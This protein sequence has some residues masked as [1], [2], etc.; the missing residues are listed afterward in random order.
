MCIETCTSV[1]GIEILL[2]DMLCISLFWIIKEVAVVDITRL[3]EWEGKNLRVLLGALD[4]VVGDSIVFQ[5]SVFNRLVQLTSKN[6]R[7]SDN[8]Q[9][10]DQDCYSCG[11]RRL[12]CKITYWKKRSINGADWEKSIKEEK[13]CVRLYCRRRRRKRNRSRRRRGNIGRR[14]N[15]RRRRRKTEGETEEEETEKEE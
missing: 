9:S 3:Y 13:F 6:S 11:V 7:I 12:K 8:M 15:R 2:I 4:P 14:R 1:Y 5:T 10:S